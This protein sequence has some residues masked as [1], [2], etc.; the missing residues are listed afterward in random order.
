MGNIHTECG[1]TNRTL[2]PRSKPN[3]TSTTDKT[4]T[5]I[6]THTK[7][8]NYICTFTYTL[9]TRNPTRCVIQ[10]R[11]SRPGITLAYSFN[12]QENA[13]QKPC[14]I[15]ASC[16]KED[17]NA[18]TSAECAGPARKPSSNSSRLLMAALVETCVRRFTC[19]NMRQTAHV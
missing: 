13:C 4:C 15:S 16:L 19:R 17:E 1:I 5:W 7:P 9:K 14:R 2:Y 6:F 8:D 11:M 18:S 10:V 3:K 12:D